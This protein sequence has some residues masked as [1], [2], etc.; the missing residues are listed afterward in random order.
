MGA[1]LDRMPTPASL[2]AHNEVSF[3]VKKI[4]HSRPIKAVLPWIVQQEGENL[5]K[6]LTLGENFGLILC[7]NHVS[8][9]DTLAFGGS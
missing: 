6:G 4:T 8:V 3:T 5:K 1:N 2:K 9:T 7:R